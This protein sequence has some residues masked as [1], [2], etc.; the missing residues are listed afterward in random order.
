ME[1]K[2][3]KTEQVQ[4]NAADLEMSVVSLE[5]ENVEYRDVPID[6]IAFIKHP[7]QQGLVPSE[8]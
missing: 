7:C 5:T 3:T 1:L 6:N 2:R 8:D 4:G